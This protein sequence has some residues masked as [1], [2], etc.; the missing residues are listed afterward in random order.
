LQKQP[1][2]IFSEADISG[3]TKPITIPPKKSENDNNTIPNRQPPSPP[4]D[5]VKRDPLRK[6][7]ERIETPESD[8][9][10]EVADNKAAST[11]DAPLTEQKL[12]DKLLK[13]NQH[14]RNQALKKQVQQKRQQR[15]N[16]TLKKQAQ[17][18]RQ[19]QAK[20]KT[21]ATQSDAAVG[22]LTAQSAPPAEL[23]L[24]DGRSTGRG[25]PIGASTPLRLSAGKHRITFVSSGHNYSF[26]VTIKDGEQTNLSRVLP[27]P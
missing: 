18:K 3:I 25:T 2:N 24:V 11:K 9:N 16:Q 23:V 6:S 15:R 22:Y 13:R 26:Q 7:P 8:E 14:K 19:Q 27:I 1:S 12:R 4:I 5:A 20:Q 21:A 17:R 10:F